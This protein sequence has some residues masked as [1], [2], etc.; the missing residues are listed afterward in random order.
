MTRSTLELRGYLLERHSYAAARYDLKFTRLHRC[1][2]CENKSQSEQR[3]DRKSFAHATP[4]R[5][6]ALNTL[7]ATSPKRAQLS[8]LGR[9]AASR[10]AEKPA[11]QFRRAGSTMQNFRL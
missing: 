1:H 4:S 2:P 11:N 5:R 10:P 7:P 8:A 3:A 6:V 9:T